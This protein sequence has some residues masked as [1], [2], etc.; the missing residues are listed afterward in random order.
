MI[1]NNNQQNSPFLDA[2]PLPRPLFKPWTLPT[3]SPVTTTARPS[4]ILRPWQT[5]STSAHP[6]L[7]PPCPADPPRPQRRH[8]HPPLCPERLLCLPDACRCR[9]HARSCP[10]HYASRPRR[11]AQA[12]KVHPKQDRMPHLSRQEDQG[13]HHVLARA[14]IAPR[15]IVTCSA[16]RPS[17]PVFAAVMASER[18]VF[19]RV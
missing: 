10:L 1:R 13:E 12:S 6:L 11:P 14:A 7:V 18:Y 9:P 16:T 15:L 5:A 2:P 17:P 3:M 19:H 4:P 8:P